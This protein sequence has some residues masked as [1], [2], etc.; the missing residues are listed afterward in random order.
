MHEN[1]S[2]F[3]IHNQKS[4]QNMLNVL[5]FFAFIAM[6]NNCFGPHLLLVPSGQLLKWKN[7]CEQHFSDFTCKIY[8]GGNENRLK[9][10]NLCITTLKV[11]LQ[12]VKILSDVFWNY[13][14]LHCSELKSKHLLITSKIKSQSRFLVTNSA[15]SNQANLLWVNLQFLMPSLFEEKL[16]I[17]K[18]SS[19]SEVV[20]KLYSILLPYFLAQ[21]EMFVDSSSP[22]EINYSVPLSKLQEFLYK[23]VQQK[24]SN[25]ETLLD[26]LGCVLQLKKI[27]NHPSLSEQNNISKKETEVDFQS[28]NL[29]TQVEEFQ[30]KS[31]KN[32]EKFQ[33]IHDNSP[34]FNQN[35]VDKLD[36]QSNFLEDST[37]FALL[38]ALLVDL[39]KTSSRC[40]LFGQMDC[41]LDIL[42]KFFQLNS[43]SYLR[44]DVSTTLQETVD[45]IENFNNNKKIDAIILSSRSIKFDFEELE[46]NS[47]IFFENEWDP[48]RE[49]KLKNKIP[50]DK[51]TLYRISTLNTIEHKLIW[52]DEK[53]NQSHSLSNIFLENFDLRNF[54]NPSMVEND[55]P[56]IK[57]DPK[58]LLKSLIQVESKKDRSKKTHLLSYSPA[59]TSLGESML[60]LEEQIKKRLNPIQNY[61]F[62]FLESQIPY[63]NLNI[64]E[65]QTTIEDSENKY[66]ESFISLIR[67]EKKEKQ[68]YQFNNTPQFYKVYCFYYFF[69]I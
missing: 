37:K 17:F 53:E 32:F 7:F 16:P 15:L 49:K 52:K 11:L 40:L 10:C 56:Q 29:K 21:E 55:T 27:C 47:I 62:R 44:I 2:S 20:N 24:Y 46:A 33:E 59:K 31:L 6:E 22:K 67:E 39:Q 45:L 61:A 19:S 1:R 30:R 60:I 57:V 43:L 50:V 48:V 12:N 23:K 18:E 36:L 9:D 69:I 34:H 63:D 25:S 64:T 54:V 65:I 51:F 41:T 35:L 58:H 8:F 38:Y 4:E 26:L 28:P 13:L 42:E 3:A 14:V 5:S 66:K 68:I